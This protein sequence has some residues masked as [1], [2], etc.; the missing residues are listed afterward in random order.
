MED[1]QKFPGMYA[2]TPGCLH[3]RLH[4]AVGFQ[5]GVRAG[6]EADLPEDHHLSQCLFSVIIGWRDARNTQKGREMFLFR[7][8]KKFSQRLSGVKPERFLADFA[9]FPDESFFVTRRLL[10]RDLTGLQFPTR[11]AGTCAEINKLVA[12]KK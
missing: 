12:E 8:D 5:S 11:I 7:T 10:P 4:D 3:K 1:V 9:Q 6:A 2:L